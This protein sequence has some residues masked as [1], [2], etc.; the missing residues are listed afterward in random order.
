[1][2]NFQRYIDYTSFEKRKLEGSYKKRQYPLSEQFAPCGY[3]Y[4]TKLL[5]H[6]CTIF[7]DIYQF[8]AQELTKIISLCGPKYVFIT[9]ISIR[10]KIRYLS[11]PYYIFIPYLNKIELNFNTIITILYDIIS[12]INRDSTHLRSKEGPEIRKLLKYRRIKKI[13][14]LILER[15]IVTQ[16]VLNANIN[17]VKSETYIPIEEFHYKGLTIRQILHLPLNDTL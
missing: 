13:N 2:S 6:P 8:S 3:K 14:H 12:P 9:S 16:N 15:K 7:L 4:F 1:M 10:R 5:K 11:I 17:R